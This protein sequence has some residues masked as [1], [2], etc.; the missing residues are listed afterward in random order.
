MA[1]F[2]LDLQAFA[3]KAGNRADLV[4]KRV[5]AGLAESIIQMSPV[6]DGTYWKNPPPKG[7]VGG[8]FRANWDYHF[9]KEPSSQRWR[10]YPIEDKTGAISMDRILSK[11]SRSPAAGIHY[12][13]N[14]LPY[15]IP[16]ENGW[17]R[18][19]PTGMVGVTVLKF[20]QMVREAAQ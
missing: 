11:L 6:G 16:L 15:A 8:R 13:G 2:A 5:V 9:D 7:Y 19:A 20:N 3:T 14:N 12:I 18:Q 1:S 10:Q 4:V 17:S